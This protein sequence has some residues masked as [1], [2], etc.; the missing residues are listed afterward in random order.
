MREGFPARMCEK[1]EMNKNLVGL[2]IFVCVIHVLSLAVN[3]CV[4]VY[5]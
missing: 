3:Q 2:C 4:C 1:V 5:L